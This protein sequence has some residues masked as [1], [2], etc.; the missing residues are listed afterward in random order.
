M[1]GK[2]G[3]PTPSFRLQRQPHQATYVGMR[4]GI[5]VGEG[6]RAQASSRG[7]TRGTEYGGQ[8]PSEFMASAAHQ[9]QGCVVSRA[10][11][12]EIL[13]SLAQV[14]HPT[15]PGPGNSVGD[16]SSLGRC[17]VCLVFA[18][19]TRSLRCLSNLCPGTR[20]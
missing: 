4:E 20:A 6:C 3:T 15:K 1:L 5:R 9:H 8:L 18:L 2:Q 17:L 11:D 13:A 10:K 7:R 16:S 12:R 14:S 19:Q